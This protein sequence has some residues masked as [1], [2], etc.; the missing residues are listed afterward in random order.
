MARI[1]T[2]LFFSFF[3]EKAQNTKEKVLSFLEKYRM[4]V[5]RSKHE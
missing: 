5:I 3:R 1:K 2:A 4:V